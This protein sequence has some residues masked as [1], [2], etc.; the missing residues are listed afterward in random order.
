MSR[1]NC[2]SLTLSTVLFLFLS[3]AL[4]ARPTEPKGKLDPVR[5]TLAVE[6]SETVASGRIV[7][8]L[9]ATIEE[10]WRLYAPT[11]PK[12]GPIPTELKLTDNPVIK[13]WTSYQPK[14]ETKFDLNFNLESQTYSDE[15][16]FLF[17]IKLD[18]DTQVGTF[19][20]ESTTRYN[21][22][23]DRLCLPPAKRSALA[24]F[25]VVNETMARAPVIPSEYEDI[26]NLK[27]LTSVRKVHTTDPSSEGFRQF[28][29]V[30]FGFGILAIFTP[31]VFP[32]IPIMMSYFVT[33]HTGSRHQSL[34]Q[35]ATFCI[36]VVVLFTSIGA[37]VSAA[38][39]PFGISQMGSSIWVNLFIALVFLAF[40][41]NLLGV[42]DIGVPSRTL[43]SLNQISGRGGL[44][45]TLVMGLVF[46]LSSFACIGPFMGTLLAG[47]IKGDLTW[48]ILGMMIFAT[49]LVLPFFFLAL[50]PAYLARLPKSGDWLT[51]TKVTV[52]FLVFAAAVKYLSN[53][54]QVGQWSLLTRERVIAIWI[55]LLAMAGFYLLGM[56]RITDEKP[57]LVGPARLGLGMLFLVLA[58]SMTPG[59]VGGKLGELDAYIPS[60]EDSR[61][62]GS[63]SDA[64]INTKHWLKNNYEGALELA[65]R[66]NKAVLV[67][68]TGYTCTNCHWMKANMFTRPELAE[69]LDELI[70]VE[71]YTDGT[72][73]A[74]Q[75]NQRMQL[76]RFETVAIPYYAIIDPGG[77]VLAEFP[78]RTRDVEQFRKFLVAARSRAI[79]LSDL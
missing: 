42:F 61:F 53:V 23:N 31:C 48:P 63:V 39:G 54:D 29:A 77:D 4:L 78:G 69:T 74:S 27:A 71:L 16:V 11:T 75:A 9:I 13:A 52:S 47:S 14:P 24:T 15:V 2:F 10:G 8:R 25:Q 44:L 28:A 68:F 6:P 67:S 72:D 41:A 20:I 18:H 37:V 30:A 58:I 19:Q 79:A 34:L 73:E 22:C 57:G 60:S 5:W 33:T 55:V 36:G 45:G 40:G 64:K 7:G 66:E 38:L 3:G 43:T 50:F 70:L 59:M 46:A 56:L 62:Q 65:R 49:G 17:D 35:A 21:A 32:M 76:K 51:R 12:G 26:K 1:Y